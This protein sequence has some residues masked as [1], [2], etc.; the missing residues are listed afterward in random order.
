MGVSSLCE[1]QPFSLGW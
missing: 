1:V